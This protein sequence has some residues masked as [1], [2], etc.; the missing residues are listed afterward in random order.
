PPRRG[1]AT[2]SRRCC[3][4]PT[5]T[6]MRP[7][8]PAATAWCPT[9]ASEDGRADP[10]RTA[11][12]AT[13]QAGVGARCAPPDIEDPTHP[14]RIVQTH[15]KHGLTAAPESVNPASVSYGTRR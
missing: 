3:G 12:S 13:A 2:P 6:S 7:S 5:S 15:P 14:F 10:L 9:D 4:A 11:V 8:G 1:P